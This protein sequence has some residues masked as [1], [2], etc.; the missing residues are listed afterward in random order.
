M[1]FG[2]GVFVTARQWMVSFMATAIDI[3]SSLVPIHYLPSLV[4]IKK[5]NGLEGF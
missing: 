1:D 2:S 4:L 5:V 3:M